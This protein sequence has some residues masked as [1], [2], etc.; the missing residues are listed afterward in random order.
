M[1]GP[2]LRDF[3]ARV[4]DWSLDDEW[5]STAL[6]QLPRRES[7]EQWPVF[8]GRSEVGDPVLCLG[9]GW[10]DLSPREQWARARLQ[11]HHFLLGHLVEQA[12]R[13]EQHWAFFWQAYHYLPRSLQSTWP[14][15]QAYESERETVPRHPSLQDLEHLVLR[16]NIL[17]RFPELLKEVVDQQ[18][19]WRQ[20]YGKKSTTTSTEI[21]RTQVVASLSTSDTPPSWSAWVSLSQKRKAKVLDW[22]NLL[23]RHLRKYRRRKLDFTHKRISKRYGT[24]P[25]I[26]LRKEAFIGVV[27][28]TSASMSTQLL[29]QFYQ[30]LQLVYQLGHRLLLLE[31]DTQIRC[32]QFF[33]PARRKLAFPGRG[34]TS[35]DLAIRYLRDKQVDLVLYY[36]DGLGPEPVATAPDLLWM[37]EP[38]PGQTPLIQEKMRNWAGEKIFIV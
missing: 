22:S 38:P 21:L 15:W 9:Q 25:G 7:A 4:A 20:P 19:F 18:S 3:A 2:L 36:T 5:L 29:T 32:V 17:A 30:E 10:R 1:A 23:R 11:V 24:A 12:L 13:P 27:L 31:A 14:D 26:R 33:D 34:N 16:H 28:D 6:V 8:W 37:V 35:Y